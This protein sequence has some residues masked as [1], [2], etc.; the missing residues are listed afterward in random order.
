MEE[1][2]FSRGKEIRTA[3]L[4]FLRPPHEVSEDEAVVRALVQAEPDPEICGLSFWTD[5]ALLAE[6]G[7]PTV[8][9]GPVGAGAHADV[10][11][12]SLESCCRVYAALRRMIRAGLS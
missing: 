5:A 10:E 1:T 4:V 11:W 12:V 8:I 3:E 7:V 9:Y 6:A 2:G